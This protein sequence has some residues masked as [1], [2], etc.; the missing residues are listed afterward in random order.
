MDDEKCFE[1]V[2]EFV[3]KPEA[4]VELCEIDDQSCKEEIDEFMSTPDNL[5]DQVQED[6]IE[7]IIPVE[8]DIDAQDFYLDRD[9]MY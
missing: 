8:C 4:L 6:E 7:K 2:N 3:N 5:L 9:P 1:E